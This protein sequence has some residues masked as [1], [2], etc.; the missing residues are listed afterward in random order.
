MAMIQK[1]L[2][3]S[4]LINVLDAHLMIL[5]LAFNVTQLNFIKKV[6]LMLVF[7]AILLVKLAQVH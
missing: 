2:A 5:V 3:S 1:I 4:V 6:E 7:H